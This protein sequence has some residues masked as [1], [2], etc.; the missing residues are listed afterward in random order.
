MVALCQ[1]LMGHPDVVPSGQCEHDFSIKL[2]LC[3]QNPA[4]E[5]HT[6]GAES[7]PH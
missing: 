7:K 5:M 6:A 1:A 4:Q 3:T 2:L